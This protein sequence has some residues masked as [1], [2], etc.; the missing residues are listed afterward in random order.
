MAHFAELDSD[1]NVLQV[2]VFSNDDINAHGGDLSVGAEQWVS[3][4]PHTTSENSHTGKPGVSWKQ[5]SMN[6]NFRGSFAGVGGTY[7][8][9]KNI[10]INSKPF[11]S[12]TLNADGTWSAPVAEPTNP[13][14]PNN[15][16]EFSQWWDEENQR[17]LRF[18]IEDPKPRT[19]Y[20]WN[21]NNSQ[22][23]E[24]NLDG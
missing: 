11:P 20:V 9:I 13:L 4:T 2:L 10:F 18:R 19:N 17:W 12:F 23:E 24:V 15:T 3:T 7:D 6:K 14:L 22:W 16:K 21:P 1:N 5:T 8:P